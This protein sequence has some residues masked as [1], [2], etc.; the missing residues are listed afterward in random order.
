MIRIKS[1]PTCN[2]P[3]SGKSW[4]AWQK[5]ARSVLLLSF[6]N[7][8][9]I[10]SP[11]LDTRYVRLKEYGKHSVP[12]YHSREGE[13]GIWSGFYRSYSFEPLKM[14]WYCGLSFSFL[15][16]RSV[17]DSMAGTAASTDRLKWWGVIKMQESMNEAIP[18]HL[19][20]AAGKFILL[21]TIY[22]IF[23]RGEAR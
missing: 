19:G 20:M 6:G 1:F 4:K 17:A 10:V 23:F 9:Q 8:R 18:F 16:W 15:P 12:R 13:I 21:W 22:V 3:S 2:I 7:S 5:L 11:L 14:S